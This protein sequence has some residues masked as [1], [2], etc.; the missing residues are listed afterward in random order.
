MPSVVTVLDSWG[1]VAVESEDFSAGLG[2]PCIAFIVEE[3]PALFGFAEF[4]VR[5]ESGSWVAE[6]DELEFFRAGLE[7]DAANIY[8][9]LL[10]GIK[11]VAND[12]EA[13]GVEAL[14]DIDSFLFL[15]FPN[16]N[17][18]HC[19]DCI[20]GIASDGWARGIDR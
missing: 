13:L 11:F 5:I 8:D 1:F 19:V 3:I 10:N 2:S 17:D 12:K 9:G 16:G 6:S 18:R 14:E 7:V 15:A 4:A 20:L